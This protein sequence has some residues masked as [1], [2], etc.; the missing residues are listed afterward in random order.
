MKFLDAEGVR[1]LWADLKIRLAAKLGKTEQAT[2]SA[3]LDGKS[4]SEFATAAQGAKA[5]NAQP[6]IS[7]TGNT[8]LL[9]APASAGGQPTTKAVNTLLAAPAAQTAN[10]QLLVAPSTQGAAPGIKAI[11]DFYQKPSTGIP[12]TD[13][14]SAVQSA[15]NSKYLWGGAVTNSGSPY[16]SYNSLWDGGGYYL[17]SLGRFDTSMT[18]AAQFELY[19]FVC[20]GGVQPS[21]SNFIKLVGLSNSNILGESTLIIDITSY[22]SFRLRNSK[23]MNVTV[24]A[25]GPGYMVDANGNRI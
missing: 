23:S 6:A 16:F 3:K 5:D 1:K 14:A 12:L 20:H 18:P 13:L 7:V 9:L 25:I 11:T 8:N 21:K 15:I 24:M 2:D 4:A 17:V 19:L 22:Y 10:T